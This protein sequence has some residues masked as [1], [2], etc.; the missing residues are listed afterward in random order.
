MEN[1]K[2]IQMAQAAR[3]N[4]LNDTAQKKP[5]LHKENK[6][7][8]PK[9][10]TKL[11]SGF[12]NKGKN[13]GKKWSRDMLKKVAKIDNLPKNVRESIPFKGIMSNG[14]IETEPGTFTKTYMLEDVNFD[15]VKESE[16][17]MIFKSFMD[18]LNSFNEK[19]RWEITIFNREINK[20]RTLEDIRIAPYRDGLNKY[21]Q[22]MNAIY[23]DNL[24]KG[25][26]S[27]RQDKYLTV[28]IDDNDVEHA[29]TVFK[30][31][32]AEISKKIS[33]MSGAPTAPLNIES[34][35]RL[36][37]DIYNQ[38]SD[39]RLA[40]GLMNDGSEVLNL[41][42]IEKLGLSVKDIIGPPGMK[43]SNNY[44]ELGDMYARAMYLGR[45]PATLSTSFLS[46][47]SDIQSNM[48]ISITSEMIPQTKAIKMALNKYTSLDSQAA[49]YNERNSQN[50]IYASLPPTLK[51][52]LKSAEAFVD[53]LTSRDQ[54]AF[55]LTFT[56]VVF[57][58]TKEQLEAR[59]SLIK[60]VG[61]KHRCPLQPLLYQQ[62]FAFNTALPLCRND[63]DESLLYRT[64]SAAVFIPYH[65]Q[66]I[67]QKNGIF[68]G[69]NQ[70]T[71]SMILCN[72]ISGDNYN[73]IIFGMAGSGKSFIAKL[74]MLSVLLTRLD[75][76]VIVI[77]PQGEYKPLAGALRGEVIN[78]APGSGTYIN[79]LDLSLEQ[80][81]EDEPDPVTIK[82]DVVLSMIEIILKGVELGPIHA[83]LV[84][85]CVRRIYRP[86]I[87]ELNK[88]GKMSDPAKCPTLSDLYQALIELKNECFEAGQLAE[89]ISRFAIGSFDTFAH[90]TNVKTSSRF[91]VYNIKSLG[92]GMKEL[93][94]YVCTND[95]WTRTIENS[96]K[97]I[98]TWSYIDEFHL[99]LEDRR[100][101]VVLK[102][103]WKMFRKWGGCPCGI[104]QNTED[105]M[106]DE[107]TRNIVNNTSMFIMMN[108]P[109]MDRQNLAE[110][111][112]LSD[113][114]L[115]YITNAPQG[116]GLFRM[117]N[118]I[119]P[120]EWEFPKDT[121]IYRLITTKREKGA[122]FA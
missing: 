122:A 117:K 15:T 43:F 2:Q 37:Y 16:Q 102:R 42:Y 27:I 23:L 98:Y 83:S 120:F 63:I 6:S 106:R 81:D 86:Y 5:A 119:V 58:R 36:L 115:D 62:E 19:T 84:D 73:S 71:K 76:Q 70:M 60:E 32:D 26:N 114:Q 110:L 39:Y 54:N 46:D 51:R 96:K 55:F 45:V 82:S 103:I 93:G 92:R 57:A 44:F 7:A 33:K 97:H 14:I 3:R 89:A 38:D 12:Q 80:T 69:N 56:V 105:L 25:N 108:A 52:Q 99:L 17:L 10:Q 61:G 91:V 20:R 24:K 77:D 64:E 21:R 79:P 13:K 8:K 88:E 72:R 118:L 31:T 53:D 35:I 104:M 66:E 85:R 41:Q 121:E 11:N 111:L 9:S 75:S 28:A 90:R 74:E 112:G 113:S 94:L 68:Y 50:G 22:E 107:D 59:T 116:T 100:T 18:L 87:E 40:T 65:A 48:L 1:R 49:A 30:R 109:L 34:R 101:T 4:E 29:A 78:L 47:L 67:N 95:I